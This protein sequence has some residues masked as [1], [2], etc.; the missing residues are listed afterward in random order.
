M[1]ENQIQVDSYKLCKTFD[2]HLN[3]VQ[4]LLELKNG[5]LVSGSYDSMIKIYDLKSNLN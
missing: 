1:D 2:D 3:L 5:H 4:C